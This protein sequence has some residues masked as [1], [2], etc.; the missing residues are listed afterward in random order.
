M[1]HEEAVK[2]AERFSDKI[3]EIGNKATLSVRIPSAQPGG[4]IVF[5]IGGD[6]L[7]AFK[8]I[9]HLWNETMSPILGDNW[10]EKMIPEIIVRLCAQIRQPIEQFIAELHKEEDE[11]GL[12]PLAK[13][14]QDIV[15][16]ALPIETWTT[17]DIFAQDIQEIVALREQTRESEA[18]TVRAE[19]RLR[20]IHELSRPR[21]ERPTEDGG[22]DVRPMFAE[23]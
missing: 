1:T 11:Q 21:P 13:Q 10:Q 19:D 8:N 15:I 14:L 18:R 23:D 4:G 5:L 17:I 7:A 6:V 16:G 3:E 12:L 9:T 20:K 2:I 22:L